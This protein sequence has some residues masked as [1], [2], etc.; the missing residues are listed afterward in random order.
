M[1]ADTSQRRV[2]LVVDDEPFIRINAI[3]VLTDAGFDV[4]EAADADEALEII[5]THSKIGVLFTDINMPGSMDGLDLARRVH[6]MRPDIHLILTSGKVRPN[7]EQIPDSGK[8][9]GKPYQERQF[10][11]LVQAA[12]A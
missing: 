9:I 1:S 7:V 2:V 5:A 6:S 11:A 12:F 3:D 10:V 4:L 8:F